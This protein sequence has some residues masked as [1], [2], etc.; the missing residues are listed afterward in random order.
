MNVV[1]DDYKVEFGKNG[2]GFPTALTQILR[3]NKEGK[4]IHTETPWFSVKLADGR[5]AVPILEAGYEPM[6]RVDEEGNQFAQFSNLGFAA[7]GKKLD[8]WRLGLTYEFYPDGTIFLGMTFAVVCADKPDLN[9]IALRI[10]IDFEKDQYTTY[11]FRRR[12]KKL[13]PTGI[14]SPYVF[15]RGLL[16]KKPIDFKEICPLIAFDFGK[17]EKLA[18]HIECLVEDSSTIDLDPK[19]GNS[20]LHWEESGPVMT[21]EFAL[22]GTRATVK[23]Y[24]WR[25]RIGITIGQTPKKRDKAPLRFYHYFDEE[26][27]Y[28]TTDQIRKMAAEG[29]DVLALHECWRTDMQNGGIPYDEKRFI[30]LVK[31]CHKYGIRVTPY[32]RGDG[33]SAQDDKCSWFNF[34][35][36]KNFDGLYIDYGAVDGYCELEGRYPGGRYPFKRY[37]EQYRQLRRQTIG[38]DGIMTVHTGPFFSAGILASVS[39]SYVAGEGEHG[40]MLNS[41]RENNYYNESTIAPGSLWTAAFP[42]YHTPKVL[43]Y[44]ANI[45]QFPH[46]MLGEQWKSCCLSHPDEPGNVT[47]ARPLWKL[48]GLMKDERNILFDN[49]ICDDEIICDSFDTGAASFTMEDGSRLII[50]SNFTD[51]TRK[52]S[53]KMPIKQE[54]GQRC[55]LLHAGSELC[56]VEEYSI[57]D[58]IEAE[59]D[60]YGICGFLICTENNKWISRIGGFKAAYPEKDDKELAYEN[61]LELQKKVKMDDTPVKTAFLK[62]DIPPYFGTL[63]EEFWIDSYEKSHDLA[64]I[65]EKGLKTTLGFI[66]KLGLT[67]E[68]PALTECL[69]PE[70]STEW[71]PLH[72]L[73]DSGRYTIEIHSSREGANMNIKCHL[74]VNDKPT[75]EG[76]RDISFFSEIDSDH[77]RLSFH[78]NL[79]K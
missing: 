32:I 8:G 7:D 13:D 50:L 23:P 67:K 70:E 59:L 65:D 79:Q 6:Y 78:L 1:F 68:E 76:A 48:Y 30:D 20:W 44:L 12:Y 41:R 18:R 27:I 71:I 53:A 24:Y 61:R 26:K 36:K 63:E 62:V 22:G 31:E 72:E 5:V 35:L 60:A 15:E 14:F 64:A 56:T 52:C 49:D 19:H 75:E 46:V 74:M 29:A 16:E 43:P 17:K 54:Y 57:Q 28:P 40:V 45:G 4:L 69:W 11:G 55:W 66:S 47:F 21:Y 33:E 73:L 58:K 9:S 38:M 42:S 51:K 37:Y 77:S 10:P 34:Y 39:D 3:H 25:N 2:G